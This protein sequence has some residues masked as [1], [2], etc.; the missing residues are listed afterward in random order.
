MRFLCLHGRGTNSKILEI[1][2]AAIRYE[3]ADGHTYDFV[4]GALPWETDPDVKRLLASEDETFAF[5]DETN[6][7][8][9]VEAVDDLDE[10]FE[11]EGPYD[12]V[13]A[14]S[15]AVGV[16]GTWMAHRMRQGKPTFRCA[17]FLSAGGPVVDYDALREGRL[18]HLSQAEVGEII[19]IPTTHTWGASDQHAKIAKG[20]S[21][22]CKSSTRSVVVHGGGHEVPGA[23]SKDTVTRIVNMI[24]R[25]VLL[26]QAAA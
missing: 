13:I 18:V 4:D 6:L 25:A 21:Q 3:L 24:R 15:Q 12:G 23:G 20:V 10:F 7:L 16:A 1:Q 5:F 2:T 17:I 8:T 26:A 22:L 14:F 9:A 19:D 11:D